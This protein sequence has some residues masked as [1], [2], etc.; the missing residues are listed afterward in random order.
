MITRGVNQRKSLF[1]Q[2]NERTTQEWSQQKA[3]SIQERWWR[4]DRSILAFGACKIAI[5]IFNGSAAFQL[6]PSTKLNGARLKLCGRMCRQRRC[7]RVEERFP[8]ER[9]RMFR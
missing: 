7:E 3:P 6:M 9:K 2:Y 1:A 5:T 4:I 8:C